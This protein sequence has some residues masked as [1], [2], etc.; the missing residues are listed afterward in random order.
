MHQQ[1][2]ADFGTISGFAVRMT[3]I[4]MDL[5]CSLHMFFF[6]PF[7]L[8]YLFP[9]GTLLITKLFYESCNASCRNLGFE[10]FPDI[11]QYFGAPFQT[12]QAV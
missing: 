7:L 12:L 9:H 3:I 8:L 2:Q 1:H 5:N 11:V 10:P 6:F 4:E